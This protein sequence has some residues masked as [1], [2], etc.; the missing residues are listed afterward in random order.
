MGRRQCCLHNVLIDWVLPS[1]AT[2]TNY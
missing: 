2:Q 1:G